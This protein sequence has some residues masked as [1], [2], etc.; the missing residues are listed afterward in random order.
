MS[1]PLYS[2]LTKDNV[3]PNVA[4]FMQEVKHLQ[5]TFNGNPQEVVQA[6]MKDGRMSQEQFNQYARVASQLMAMMRN[7]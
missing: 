2:E 7:K 4:R 5:Q 1:N 3:I 6:M